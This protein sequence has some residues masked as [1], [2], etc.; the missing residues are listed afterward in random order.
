[1]SQSCGETLKVLGKELKFGEISQSC[2]KRVKV[3]KS[4]SNFW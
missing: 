3:L 4:Q 1:M 2:K